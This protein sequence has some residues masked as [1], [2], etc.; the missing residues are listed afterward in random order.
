MPRTPLAAC[1]CA[2]VL[3]A[4]VLP[5]GAQQPRFEILRD[6]LPPG[7]GAEAV[8][9]GD[10]DGDGDPDNYRAMWGQDELL[11]ND[12][13]GV[14]QPAP[15]GLPS[16]LRPTYGGVLVDVEADGDLDLV[17][18]HGGF[19]D[20]RNR[21][22]L[23]DGQ[24]LFSE[25]VGLLPVD[26]DTSW[27]VAAADVDGDGDPDLWIGNAGQ[28]RLYLNDGAGLFSDGTGQIPAAA[29]VSTRA[30][31]LGDVDADGDLDALL[32]VGQNCSP[33]QQADRLY[34]NDGFGN[35]TEVAGALPA[36]DAPTTSVSL[37]DVDADGD[38]DLLLGS[39][40]QCSLAW[41]G[42]RLYLNDGAGLFSDGSASL[43]SSAT[44]V[45]ACALV[46]LDADG[47]L[48]AWLGNGVTPVT[49]FPP[50]MHFGVQDELYLNDGLGS[51]T[52]APA[53]LP[54]LQDWTRTGVFADLD[55]DGDLD[56][57]VGERLLLGDGSG[58]LVAAAGS[59]P[60][61]SGT[62]SRVGLGDLD[63][64]GWL[65]AVYGLA[66]IDAWDPAHLVLRGDGAGGFALV[67]GALPATARAAAAVS[68]GDVDLDGD[69][70]VLV[71]GAYDGEFFPAA[72]DSSLFLNRGG[73]SFGDASARL[74]QF[75]PDDRG[76]TRL[77]LLADLDGDSAADIL[78]ADINDYDGGGTGLS[79]Y[80]NDGA[81][82]FADA[83]GQVW[84]PMG[85]PQRWGVGDVDGDG[86]LDI[87]VGM[88]FTGVFLLLND[89]AAGFSDGS[90]ALPPALAPGTTTSLVLADVDGDLDLDA[91]VGWGEFGGNVDS[92]LWRNDGVGNFT[93]VPGSLPQQ[94]T[95]SVRYVDLDVDDDGDLDLF[96]E[97]RVL[98][99]DG[100]GN[101][102]LQLGLVGSAIDSASALVP[103]DVDRDGDTDIWVA[104]GSGVLLSNVTR[105]LAR[106]GEPR[107]GKPLVLDL[108]GPPSGFW[109]LWF[110]VG[111]QATTTPWGLLLL[112]PFGALLVSGGSLG[113]GGRAFWSVNVPASP[114]LAGVAIHW[115]AGVGLPLRFTN[116]ERTTLNEL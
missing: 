37:G 52:P 63:G 113:P 58:V 56:G 23:N 46:D 109:S 16:A 95:E 45:Q 35:F 103:A 111:T 88:Q 83:S 65:D 36:D 17:S 13:S 96:A 102:T 78:L 104:S 81:G 66:N 80:L 75:F 115:Q 14:L 29:G 71:A 92:Y 108:F 54:Q 51:F 38:L 12:G 22:W 3:S 19:S 7:S 77:G 62:V 112:D 50:Q 94:P 10:L 60:P 48:D 70:D 47:D 49:G 43:P 26:T 90:S 27:A 31:L 21:L 67:P 11:L 97:D 42:A 86:D 105:Q 59:L 41:A 100:T 6:M 87:L 110:S 79:L 107:L 1:P 73:M 2:I 33:G 101:F 98:V 30:V 28:D 84:Q 85:I 82:N 24:A 5:A 106:R 40:V 15:A 72:Q 116:V 34:R 39:S 61:L 76:I 55:A 114:A 91:V 25:A 9:V 93:D 53:S 8:L 89:G 99:G 18:L 69:L 32:G 68:T 57:L 20:A 64:D 74:P 4:V 44:D